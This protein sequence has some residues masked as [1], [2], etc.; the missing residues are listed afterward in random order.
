MVVDGLYYEE[1]G[2]GASILC[3]HGAG[4]SV[5]LWSPAVEIDPAAPEV[6]AFVAEVL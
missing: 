1:H 2:Q 4:S 3:I 5:Q 6:L